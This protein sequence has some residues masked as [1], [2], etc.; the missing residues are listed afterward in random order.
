MTAPPTSPDPRGAH[1]APAP[2]ELGFY[3]VLASMPALATYRAKFAAVIGAGLLAY[4]VAL[5]LV[6]VLGAGRIGLATLV[7]V[8][9]LLAL[10]VALVLARAVDRLLA[11]LV[12]AERAVDD[13]AF[14][15]PLARVD[16][17]GSD[18]AAQVLR[19]VQGL[20]ARVARDEREARERDAVDAA[21]GLLNRR[22]GR[23]RA[24]RLIDEE[25]RRGRRVR[26]IVADV[27]GF[28]AFN[29]RHGTG[30]GDAMLKVIAARL[31]RV[32]GSEGLA[33]RWS[34]DAFLLVH[35]GAAE[36]MPDADEMLARP[37]VVKGSAEPLQLVLGS[38]ETDERVTLDRLVA[39]AEEALAATRGRRPG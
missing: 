10:A 7:G 24:Q 37:I 9:L 19:G 15:R 4:A 11:P 14:G 38:A 29:A 35:A 32:A 3:R 16:V 26:A 2:D 12:L 23:E 5:V 27:D 30:Q 33:A 13:V 36:A 17:P 34:G 25:T 18:T 28:R 8:A 1:A 31:L 20:A 21:T 6:V 39:E 22:A